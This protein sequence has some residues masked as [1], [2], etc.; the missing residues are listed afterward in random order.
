MSV[1]TNILNNQINQL[2]S[3]IDAQ[4]QQLN[5]KL[6][7]MTNKVQLLEQRS[8]TLQQQYHFNSADSIRAI[9]SSTS[10]DRVDG[11]LD[12][13]QDE[14]TCGHKAGHY[15]G[16]GHSEPGSDLGKLRR[17]VSVKRSPDYT[18]AQPKFNEKL[19]KLIEDG[20]SKLLCI[21]DFDRTITP[22]RNKSG[23]MCLSSHGIIENSN[24]LPQVY[25]EN[26]QKLFHHYYPI[27]F[28]P[29][30]PEDIKQTQLVEWWSRS[31]N[32]LIDYGVSKQ[33]IEECVSDAI[34]TGRALLR[35]NT[36]ELFEL[37]HK[38]NINVIV[39]SAGLYD[40]IHELFHQFDLLTPNVTIASN[41]MRFDD[42]GKLIGFKDQLIHSL[43]KKYT[44]IEQQVIANVH[45]NNN[46]ITQSQINVLLFGDN[47]SDIKMSDGLNN[48]D[49]MI[50]FGFVNDHVD[51]RIPQYTP[52]FDVLILDDGSYQ[53]PISVVQKI[54]QH[55]NVN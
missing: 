15:G 52:L 33:L 51:Q 42:T 53:F 39:F 19:D 5:D 28:D 46:T 24:V 50:K 4:L 30:I 25:R 2:N 14:H 12:S 43:N 36:R 17:Q 11:D 3:N 22:L 41:Q 8:N 37:L 6:T 34:S 29:N 31:H 47:V 10:T 32:L 21:F 13:K 18:V 45:H 9:N 54:V 38:H 48:I 20:S 35:E 7:S 23:D 16:F 27:E 49:T 55:N 1:N 44:A 40:V 26:A